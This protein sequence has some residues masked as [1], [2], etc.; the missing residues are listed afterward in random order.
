MSSSCVRAAIS[1]RLGVGAP[2][3]P[4]TPAAEVG[5]PSG[6]PRRPPAAAAAT[7]GLGT[8]A[9]TAPPP[10]FCESSFL[11]K[12][13]GSNRGEVLSAEAAAA[14][15]AAAVATS[16]PNLERAAGGSRVG[17]GRP[18]RGG[19]SGNFGILPWGGRSRERKNI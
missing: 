13:R 14:A 11:W 7:A 17:S 19:K 5:T 15:A 2:G 9:V 6:D 8:V 18:A 10:T 4:T 12:A 3:A 1:Y 16:A